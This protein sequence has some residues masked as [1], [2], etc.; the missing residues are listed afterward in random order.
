[1]A[2][3]SR[4][5][6]V[7]EPEPAVLDA[8][9]ALGAEVRSVRAAD[10]STDALTDL[11][12][13]YGTRRIL[14]FGD[15][16]AVHRAVEDTLARLFPQRTR[17]LRWLQDPA[18]MRRMLNQS[19]VSVVNAVT[20]RSVDTALAWAEHLPLPLVIKGGP[21]SDTAFVHSG[22]DLRDWAAHTPR[23]PGVIEEFL[24]GP[25][26]VVD[27]F[28]HAGMHHVLGVT[29][30]EDAAPVGADLLYPAALTEAEAAS[31]RSTV[32]ALLD[33]AGHESGPV[34][35][36]VVLTEGGPRI[37]AAQMSP[38]SGPFGR[39]REASTGRHPGA[40]VLTL[41]TGRAGDPPS[42]A[43][44]SGLARLDAPPEPDRSRVLNL[45]AERA[46]VYDLRIVEG[47]VARGHAEVIIHAGSPWEV[48]R[49]ATAIR[50]QYRG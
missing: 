19:R 18:A 40:D 38:V 6:L 4:W 10:V 39:L 47:P 22:E 44:F 41:I 21:D 31:V 7:I 48:A 35:T 37:T 28:T 12:S 16:P 13:A 15:S 26:L 46:D 43:R 11:A 2:D 23:L 34:R 17:T 45:L 27:T 9:A 20:V 50:E 33:L 8:A 24:A 25:R 1:M 32:R 30:A 14:Y 3:R 5:M 36:W 49:R 42:P 29:A